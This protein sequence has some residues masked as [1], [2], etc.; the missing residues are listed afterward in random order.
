MDNRD[1]F[2]A[3]C[4]VCRGMEIYMKKSNERLLDLCTKL[5]NCDIGDMNQREIFEIISLLSNRNSDFED[6]EKLLT[7]Y[8]SYLDLLFDNPEQ[9]AMT[10]KYGVILAGLVKLIRESAK[11][12]NIDRSDNYKNEKLGY[13]EK[14]YFFCKNH[15]RDRE[16]NIC[17]RLASMN[18]DSGAEIFR[19]AFLDSENRVLWIEDIARGDFGNVSIDIP[20]IFRSALIRGAKGI[21]IAHNHPD[22]NP[23]PSMADGRVT[24]RFK[25]ACENINIT[26]VD[27]IIVF[28]GNY[29]SIYRKNGACSEWSEDS[30]VWERFHSESE[31]NGRGTEQ[32][33]F[34]G[35]FR[36]ADVKPNDQTF[37]YS[38][39]E[40]DYRMSF[41]ELD[42]FD[43]FKDS[44]N[45]DFG[46]E[47][48]E[49]DDKDD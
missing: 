6:T 16:H 31:T 24:D 26:F 18:F 1:F 17:L 47:E 43:D 36:I 19:A 12:I 22:G 39:A 48:I 9:I 46:S 23:T 13:G 2:T 33:G 15:S 42:L 25:K 35:T 34:Y 29:R 27:H 41:D 45:L 40:E 20:K 21:L 11:M 10:A 44:Y 5:L 37:T 30:Q 8:D 4:A 32:S 49:L 14:A 38:P 28:R 7:R 3:I